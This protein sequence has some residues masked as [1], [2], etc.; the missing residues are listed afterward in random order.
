MSSPLTDV[1][2]ELLGEIT[3]D[4][5]AEATMSE[6]NSG[7]GLGAHED[8]HGNGFTPLNATAGTLV[9]VSSNGDEIEDGKVS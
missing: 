4:N 2:R 5:G 1:D 8:S 6:T 9:K 7:P 3:H